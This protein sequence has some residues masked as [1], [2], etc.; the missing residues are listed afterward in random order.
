MATN[1]LPNGRHRKKYDRPS[2]FREKRLIRNANRS[3]TEIHAIAQIS[4]RELPS[5]YLYKL[6]NP[7]PS[8][9]G[10][11]QSLRDAR[12]HENVEAHI[13]GRLGR[14]KS[15]CNSP[16]H[17]HW[18]AGAGVGVGMLRGRGIPLIEI[19][20][21]SFKVSWFLGFLVSWFH[22]FCWFLGFKVSKF[23]VSNIVQCIL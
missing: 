10:A 2:L 4:Y 9:S 19:K 3:G 20:S 21:S 5:T 12:R 18:S 13:Y 14:R 22:S 11:W 6:M 15:F 1:I 16:N 8:I 17:Q 7:F 23:K